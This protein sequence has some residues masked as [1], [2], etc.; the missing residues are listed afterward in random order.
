MRAEA[1]RHIAPHMSA[2][3]ATLM[4]LTSDLEACHNITGANMAHGR[5]IASLKTYN[6][7]ITHDTLARLI[8][9]GLVVQ[10]GFGY[11]LSL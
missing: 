2:G 7:K 8:K 6:S 4:I 11:K 5:T 1:M 10:V 3:D 9:K